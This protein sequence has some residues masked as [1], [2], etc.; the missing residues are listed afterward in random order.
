MEHDFDQAQHAD[1]GHACDGQGGCGH[2]HAAAASPAR[3]RF[4][5]PDNGS[6]VRAVGFLGLSVGSFFG[7]VYSLNHYGTIASPIA[8]ILGT[9]GMLS[10]WAAMIHVTGGER[11]DD[12]PFV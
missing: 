6:L 11:F 9:V 12:H 8:A 2:D 10:M 4:E 5:R 7:A 3:P 1:D